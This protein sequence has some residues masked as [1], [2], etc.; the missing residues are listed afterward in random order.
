MTTIEGCLERYAPQVSL[1]PRLGQVLRKIREEKGA[2]QERVA[3]LSDVH[4]NFV[5]EFERGNKGLSLESFIRI[6]QALE[7][8]PSEVLSQILGHEK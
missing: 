6:C 7:K 8:E 3:E 4:R 1:Q 2:S 5:G